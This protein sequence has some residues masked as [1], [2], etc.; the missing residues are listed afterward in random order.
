[1]QVSIEDVDLHGAKKQCVGFLCIM[2]AVNLE[3]M[4]Q[5]LQEAL[6]ERSSWLGR[7]GVGVPAGTSQ[8]MP[9]DFERREKRSRCLLCHDHKRG[10]TLAFMQRTWTPHRT[11]GN[12]LSLEG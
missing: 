11:V 2:D 8:D 9:S 5:K 10:W 4:R 1:M 3:E 6:E 7:A 12:G